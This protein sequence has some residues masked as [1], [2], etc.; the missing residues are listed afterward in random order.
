[1][2][3]N[4]I[5]FPRKSKKPAQEPSETWS[6]DMQDHT[7]SVFSITYDVDHRE[8]DMALVSDGHVEHLCETLCNLLR[9]QPRLN[10]YVSK[11]LEYMIK[12]ITK[13]DTHK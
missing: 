9:A 3:D 8:L 2:T 10:K 5:E 7:G 1:M 13:V 6:F 11:T 4:I 12:Q